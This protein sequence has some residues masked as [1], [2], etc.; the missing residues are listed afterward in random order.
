MNYSLA[1]AICPV[2]AYFV[3]AISGACV[4]DVEAFS[5]PGLKCY[6][7]SNDHYPH[8]FEILKRGAWAARVFFLQT[9]RK[10][11]LRW[12]YKSQWKGRMTAAE[13]SELLALVLKHK[14]RLLR[15]WNEK[16]TE[17]RL[18]TQNPSNSLPNSNG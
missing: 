1:L 2:N 11:G 17:A 16:V 6:F 4:G 5:I 3:F 14:K 10:R 12:E 9:T 13:E 7:G 8:H 15:E 18:R